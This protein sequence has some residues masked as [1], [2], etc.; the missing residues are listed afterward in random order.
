L[1]QTATVI[2]SLSTRVLRSKLA[3][4]FSLITAEAS[5]R[6]GAVLRGVHAMLQK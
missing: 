6:P 3:A 4:N 2:S 5:T 1:L